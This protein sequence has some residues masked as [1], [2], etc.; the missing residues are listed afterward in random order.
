VAERL[1]RL[2]AGRLRWRFWADEAVVYN[3]LSGDTLLLDRLGASVFDI[4]L[5]RRITTD[6]LLHE[7]AELAG[8]TID[9]A[10]RAAVDEVLLDLDRAR[11]AGSGRRHP[12]GGGRRAALA[13][14][15]ADGRPLR[16][17]AP[18]A[19]SR[20][21]GAADAGGALAALRPVAPSEDA[22]AD[23]RAAPRAQGISRQRVGDAGVE[24]A[25]W[26]PLVNHNSARLHRCRPPSPAAFTTA[27]LPRRK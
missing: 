17:R 27:S 5:E 10:L 23:S 1:W 11:I 22:G 7:L 13:A 12:R 14:P 4:L 3:D 21:Q 19:A 18:A 15:Q 20:A 2:A 9:A 8:A 26:L 16:S 25:E 6:A 24:A